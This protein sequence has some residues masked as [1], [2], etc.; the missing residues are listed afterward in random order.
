MPYKDPEAKKA[1]RCRNLNRQREYM[2]KH[3]E[4]HHD[5]YEEQRAARRE[6]A[7][8]KRLARPSAVKM[9]EYQ[10][11][12]RLRI[13]IEGIRLLGGRCERCGFDDVRALQFD[14][15]QPL[16]RLSSGNRRKDST[17]DVRKHLRLGTLREIFQLLCANCHT[18]KTR[19]GGEY[20]LRADGLLPSPSAVPAPLPLFQFGVLGPH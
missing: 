13:R 14:H 4:M 10:R 6:V 19:E 3:R 18:I 5:R 7:R 2:R 12:H 9:P 8:Q 15:K 17:A 1:W 16:L 20:T 11:M